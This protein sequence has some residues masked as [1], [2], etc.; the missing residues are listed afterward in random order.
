MSLSSSSFD[1]GDLKCSNSRINA[2]FVDFDYPGMNSSV[3]D[4]HHV[5]L[6]VQLTQDGPLTFWPKLSGNPVQRGILHPN[7]SHAIES[8]F[9]NLAFIRF[10]RCSHYEFSAVRYFAS[11]FGHFRASC[12][13][14]VT[15]ALR[16]KPGKARLK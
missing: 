11:N 2:R 13:A 1:F 8:P 9:R 4:D 15:K 6:A 16:L 5:M 7:H 12:G 10:T 14:T 3:V